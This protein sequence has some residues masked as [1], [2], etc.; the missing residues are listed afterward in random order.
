MPLRL[1]IVDDNAAFLEAA[2]RLL[3]R[4]GMSVVGVASTSLDALRRV[5]EL[6]PDVTLVDVDL[7]EES[8]F[9][10]AYRLAEGTDGERP[11]RVILISAYAEQ[12]LADLVDACPA[13][14]FLPKS[15]LSGS[16]I[17]EVLE[18]TADGPA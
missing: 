13:V 4:E 18:R 6:R 1:L 8:G 3:E 15:R 16:A 11:S 5:D 12:D 7:G 2:R 17:V 14:G 9:D 10:L